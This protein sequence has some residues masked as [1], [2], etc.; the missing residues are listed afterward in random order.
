M[1]KQQ[2]SAPTVTGE[3]LSF[4]MPLAVKKKNLGPTRAGKLL[5][6]VTSVTRQ[7]I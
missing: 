1:A 6:Y 2:D 7:D 5:Q 3:K 4:R